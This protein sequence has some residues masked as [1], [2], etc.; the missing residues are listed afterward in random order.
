MKIKHAIL[1]LAIG[2]CFDFIGAFNK[3]L[4]TAYGDALLAFAMVLKVIG[5]IVFVYK[6]FTYPKA[7]DF[8]EW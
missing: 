4:H 7:K 1:L 2:Y 8:L 3:I 5:V 6:L